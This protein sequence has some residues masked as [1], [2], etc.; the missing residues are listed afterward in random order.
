M[1]L[2]LGDATGAETAAE[3]L[4]SPESRD[5]SKRAAGAHASTRFIPRFQK[6]LSLDPAGLEPGP[7]GELDGLDPRLFT[8]PQ[9][10]AGNFLPGINKLIAGISQSVS[11]TETALGRFASPRGSFAVGRGGGAP[12]AVGPGGGSTTVFAGAR[13]PWG[14]LNFRSRNEEGLEPSHPAL[15]SPPPPSPASTSAITPEPSS[16]AL[17]CASS[18]IVVQVIRRRWQLGKK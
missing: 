2:Q 12:I 5:R 6:S 7:T 10:L 3:T 17:F 15:T 4:R 9:S 16:Q 18:F 1:T 14:Q 8:Q 11:V 13:L